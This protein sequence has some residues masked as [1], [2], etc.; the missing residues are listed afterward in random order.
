MQVVL[1]LAKVKLIDYVACQQWIKLRI[2]LL[3]CLTFHKNV[4]LYK[5]SVALL[6]EGQVVGS[7]PETVG[8]LSALSSSFRVPGQPS[9]GCTA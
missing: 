2:C 4:R 8:Y 5:S 6:L 3:A 7:L 9:I 1:R